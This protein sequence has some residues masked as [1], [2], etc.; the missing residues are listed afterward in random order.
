MKKVDLPETILRDAH[1]SLIATRLST[2]EMLPVL[3]QLDSAGYHSLEMWGGATFWLLLEISWRRS[4]GETKNY[5]K[6]SKE[7]ESS[8]ALKRSKFIRIQALF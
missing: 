5:K 2:K 8:N 7:N 4:M 6:S 1:Q 3:Q